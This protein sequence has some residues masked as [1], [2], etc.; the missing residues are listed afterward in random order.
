MAPKNNEKIMSNRPE[1]YE[2]LLT[3]F[4][5]ML[6]L[7]DCF[8]FNSSVTREVYEKNMEVVKGEVIT[9][10]HSGVHDN[11]VMKSFDDTRLRLGFIGNTAPYKGYPLLKRILE[12]L[13]EKELT[14]W[15]LSVYGGGVGI[16][17]DNPNIIYKGK[18][19]TG[20]MKRIYSEMDLLIVPSLC[21]ETFSLITLEALSFGV[22]VMVSNT[23]GAKDIVVCYAPDFIFST[24]EELK[25]KLVNLIMDRKLLIDYNRQIIEQP[26]LYTLDKHLDDLDRLYHK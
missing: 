12:I 6:S 7:V 13:S 11:R 3:H 4:K 24:P 15:E 2:G 8:H 14:D 20:E 5:K 23:V 18:F 26:W 9:I 10:T 19:A 25:E 17:K 22:P 16:D 21:Y 1:M